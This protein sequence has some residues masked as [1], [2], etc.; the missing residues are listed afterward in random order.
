MGFDYV[1]KVGKIN[2]YTLTSSWAQILTRAE[3]KGIRGVKIKSRYTPG[4]APGGFDVAFN[5]APGRLRA[6]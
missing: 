3:A 1:A 6:V 5:A 2:V 4:S